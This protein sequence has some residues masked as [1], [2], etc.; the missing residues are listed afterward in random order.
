[1]SQQQDAPPDNPQTGN[2]LLLFVV[3]I[4]SLGAWFRALWGGPLPLYGVA[5]AGF[6]IMWRLSARS[7]RPFVDPM[8]LPS[9]APTLP[10]PETLPEVPAVPTPAELPVA[11]TPTAS[12]ATVVPASPPAEVAPVETPAQPDVCPAAAAA[13]TPP[14]AP[15]QPGS[16][17]ADTSAEPEPVPAPAPS[18]PLAGSAF[19]GATFAGAGE[20]PIAAAAALLEA[21]APHLPLAVHLWLRDEASQSMRRLAAAGTLLPEPHPLPLDDDPVGLALSTD[22]PAR[23]QVASVRLGLET[24]ALWRHAV[25]LVSGETRAVVAVDTVPG[26]APHP[27]V[28]GA[29]LETWAPVLVSVVA[30]FL[31]ETQR[32]EGRVL[33][34][35]I[36]LLAAAPT[37]TELLEVALSAALR[38]SGATAGSVMLAEPERHVLR[39]A[40][41]RGLPSSFADAEV[42][43]GEGIAGWVAASGKPMLVEDLPGRNDGRRSRSRSSIS[44]PIEEADVVLGVINAGCRDYPGVLMGPRMDALVLLGRQTGIALRSLAADAVTHDP[45]RPS[46]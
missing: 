29:V 1:M 18:A 11:S 7:A 40:A 2:R 5:V 28:V 46:A 6:V 19:D 9:A 20:D 27:E 37:P 42:P 13:A 41:A 23:A 22:A 31:E 25:P 4:A 34:E 32:A 16:A 44:V 21:F 15:E 35:A 12:P 39:I 26:Q 17:T 36:P 33:L 3:A 14:A 30:A 10:S 43:F 24:H 45:A 8:S 38:M